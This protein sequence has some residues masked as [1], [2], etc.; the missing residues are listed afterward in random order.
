MRRYAQN[1]TVASD[2]SRAEIER[3]LTNYGADQ[4]LYGWQDGAA[5]IGFRHKGRSIRFHLPDA[6]KEEFR[7]TAGN[8]T[9]T[10]VQLDVVMT[11]ERKRR[12]RSLALAIKAKLEACATG[13]ATFEDEFLAYTVLPNGQTVGQWAEPQLM[14]A[15]EH[16]KMP[17]GLLPAWK[18]K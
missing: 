4:F 10:D 2:R 14:A 12:W 15:Y 13:I 16:N 17:V 5:V 6:N 9:R 18:D 1:T 7:K 3:L 11:K 8:V